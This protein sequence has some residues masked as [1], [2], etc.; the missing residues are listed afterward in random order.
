MCF[1]F[2]ADFLLS[3][4]NVIFWECETSW[5]RSWANALKK[6]KEN[7]LYHSKFVFLLKK[8][9]RHVRTNYPFLTCVNFYK[10]FS[11]ATCGNPF[12]CLSFSTVCYSLL[13][14][15]LVIVCAC[16]F[17]FCTDPDPIIHFFGAPH[18]NQHFFLRFN[19]IFFQRQVFHHQWRPQLNE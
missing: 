10:K 19:Y 18:P 3:T 16:I 12:V 4:S 9:W 8:K 15:P 5:S 7:V 13:W 11:D 14:L 17:S 6:E 2:G 1:C